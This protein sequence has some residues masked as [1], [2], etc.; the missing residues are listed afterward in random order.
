MPAFI[1]ALDKTW[2]PLHV[3]CEQV[4]GWEQ[5]PRSHAEIWEALQNKA[6]AEGGDPGIYGKVV[7]GVAGHEPWFIYD[8]FPLS[9][10]RLVGTE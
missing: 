10:L 1:E 8:T 9:R 5:D 3:G 2:K 6:A 4:W 7:G